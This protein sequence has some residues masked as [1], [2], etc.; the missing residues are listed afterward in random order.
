MIMKK[1]VKINEQNQDKMRLLEEEV[2]LLQ[3]ANERLKEIQNFQNTLLEKSLVGYYV[4][5]E[6]KFCAINSTVLSYTGYSQDELIGKDAIFL[7]HPDDKKQVQEKARAM[8]QGKLA[9]PYEYR[10]ITKNHEILWIMESVTA[11]LYAGRRSVL[12]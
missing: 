10:I 6:G 11:I 3:Q 1:S 8:L 5:S 12:G 2:T 4:I 7:V 9:S